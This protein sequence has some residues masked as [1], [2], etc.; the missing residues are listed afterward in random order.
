MDVFEKFAI[1]Q[2]LSYYPEN[3]SFDEIIE[4]M[5]DYNEDVTVWDPFFNAEPEDV[6]LSRATCRRKPPNVSEANC[7]LWT[8]KF[9]VARA[10]VSYK[11][12]LSARLQFG[13]LQKNCKRVLIC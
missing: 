11:F 5:R 6:I 1:N 10:K 9:L 13:E 4:M 7:N 8:H 2:F 12:L 3:A